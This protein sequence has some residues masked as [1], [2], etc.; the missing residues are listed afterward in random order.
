MSSLFIVDKDRGNGTQTCHICAE[1]HSMQS[2][3]S[4]NA[5]T[6]RI[7]KL[8]QANSVIPSIMQA[9]KQ[10]VETARAFQGLLKVSD[11]AQEMLQE[12]LAEYGDIGKEISDKYLGKVNTWLKE[13]SVQD[14]EQQPSSQQENTIQ[15]ETESKLST[16]ETMTGQNTEK[17]FLQ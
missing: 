9:N 16:M 5:L 12:V 10:A 4:H 8:L 11:K 3:C 13:T 6:R 14:I 1:I 7:G 15:S 17:G 2:K